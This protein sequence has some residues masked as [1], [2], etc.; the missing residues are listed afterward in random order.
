MDLLFTNISRSTIQGSCCNCAL[1]WLRKDCVYIENYVSVKI[2]RDPPLFFSVHHHYYNNRTS[3]IMAQVPCDQVSHV[4]HLL[5][6]SS[7]C[8]YGNKVAR[9]QCDPAYQ[10]WLGKA[11]GDFVKWGKFEEALLVY[12]GEQMVLVTLTE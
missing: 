2:L 10:Q 1:M 12:S 7:Y 8:N 5:S 9:L 11:V 4:I 3:S 6:N